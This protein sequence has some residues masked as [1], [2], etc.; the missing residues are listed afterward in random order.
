MPRPHSFPC[1]LCTC[2]M[3]CMRPQSHFSV[4]WDQVVSFPVFIFW[5]P[6]CG[7][8]YY[9]CLSEAWT[10]GFTALQM[11][12]QGNN[13]WHSGR[14]WSKYHTS[15]RLCFL[16]PS[17]ESLMRNKGKN[18]HICREISFLG[19][20][21]ECSCL[22]TEHL[23]GEC[24]PPL[25]RSLQ[26]EC[27]ELLVEHTRSL[28]LRGKYRSHSVGHPKPSTPVIHT[29]DAVFVQPGP[30]SGCFSVRL[31]SH[32]LSHGLWRKH[33]IMAFDFWQLK[34]Y[35]NKTNH[36]LLSGILWGSQT[37]KIRRACDRWDSGTETMEVDYM[38]L[39][40]PRQGI[41]ARR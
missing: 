27:R 33:S 31:L 24:S 4:S 36:F 32:A 10:L 25:C 39:A 16:S 7:N 6:P 12:S 14:W 2:H 17:G 35:R 30:E 29:C 37:S 26:L 8:G 5:N 13:I 9:C 23:F 28:N 19:R 15:P 38:F 20:A 18:P 41:G 21:A 11:I 22:P 3:H 1:S 40:L 34:E